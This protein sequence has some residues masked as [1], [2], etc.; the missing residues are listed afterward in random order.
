MAQLVS[1]AQSINDPTQTFSELKSAL[2]SARNGKE[3]KGAARKLDEFLTHVKIERGDSVSHNMVPSL[4]CYYDSS[5][6]SIS[7]TLR[8]GAKTDTIQF[9]NGQWNITKELLP[10]MEIDL[11]CFEQNLVAEI[12]Q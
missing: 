5:L 6:L 1:F 2:I 8:Q 12:K 4:I 7:A 10:D 11:L 9:L 3:A